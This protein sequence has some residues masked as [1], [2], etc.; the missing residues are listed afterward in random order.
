MTHPS[1]LMWLVVAVGGEPG[2]TNMTDVSEPLP[3]SPVG[4]LLAEAGPLPDV[5]P[6]AEAGPLPD[7]EDEQ[8]SQSLSQSLPLPMSVQNV[9]RQIACSSEENLDDIIDGRGRRVLSCVST[10]DGDQNGVDEEVE[11]LETNEEE[12]ID[13]DLDDDVEELEELEANEEVEGE[14]DEE[15]VEEDAPQGVDE[16]LDQLELDIWKA[17]KRTVP[18]PLGGLCAFGVGVVA[19][20]MMMAMSK[21]PCQG[22]DRVYH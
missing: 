20:M 21:Q 9:G 5:E 14:I 6:L 12:E 17:M 16:R 4:H 8:L 3:A 2:T 10:M 1:N 22:V 11:E 19:W 15:E 13:W 18:V 7:N